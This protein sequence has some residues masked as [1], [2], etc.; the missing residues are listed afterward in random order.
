LRKSENRRPAWRGWR[1]E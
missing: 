1:T